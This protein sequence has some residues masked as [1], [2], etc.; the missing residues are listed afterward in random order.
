LGSGCA[1]E[2]I[3]DTIALNVR[4]QNAFPELTLDRPFDNWIANSG[5]NNEVLLWFQGF[6]QSR[7]KKV[8]LQYSPV[9]RYEWTTGRE[10][11]SGALPPDNSAMA[12]RWD[13]SD[14][15]EGKY[16]LRLR[17]DYGNDDVYST[18][19]SGLI[20]RQGPRLFGPPSPTDGVLS[21]GDLISISFD[22]AIRCFSLG[23]EQ[24]QFRN[25]ETGEDIPFEI[26]CA[27]DR[28]ILK[29][30]WQLDDQV[31]KTFEVTLFTVSDMHENT[32][33]E[34][35]AWRFT[36]EDP[37]GTPILD[38]DL[39]GVPDAA[40]NCDL[41]AN[42]DQADLDG[43]GI[44]DVCDADID[45]DG[46]DNEADNC[47]Y[48]YNPDQ[49]DRDNNGSGD[50]CEPD[51]DGDGDGV[52][53]AED[54]CPYTP[55]ADQADRDQDG[56]GDVCDEDMDGDGI[57]NLQD[58]CPSSPNPDQ[59]DLNAD[60]VGDACAS[61]VST[62]EERLGLNRISIRPNPASEQAWLEVE[63][64]RPENW[65]VAILR[66]DGRLMTQLP[67]QEWS[68]GAQGIALPVHQLSPGL[69]LVR[70]QSSEAIVTRKLIIH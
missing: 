5:D 9:N 17:A 6:D 31:G 51:A 27:G 41:A 43:D 33:S 14:M 38:A 67:V 66:P 35:L 62:A 29:P 26:G 10:W 15:P 3:S 40:D 11:Q 68:A 4:F 36:V 12:A 58:N 54:N 53:N 20:D 52:V 39:D 46:V 28:V 61:V 64:V 55:N 25:V 70:L 45:G 48:T 47:P 63:M 13:I 18:M 37:D 60:Q 59:A 69:Y 1:D 50:V 42:P 56:I 34:P 2:R 16:D 22:E 8:Q 24:I 65:S 30:L 23:A 49:G 7:V 32:N 19:V 57:R 21:S 44:G